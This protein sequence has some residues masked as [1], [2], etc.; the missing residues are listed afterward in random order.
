MWQINGVETGSIS[1]PQY[2]SATVM[3][4]ASGGLTDAIVIDNGSGAGS[5]VVIV[6]KTASTC[7]IR[8]VPGTL[9]GGTFE[10]TAL[11]IR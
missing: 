10:W 7:G 5:S 9:S 11:K 3:V 2:T 8:I 1:T 6:S 4:Y